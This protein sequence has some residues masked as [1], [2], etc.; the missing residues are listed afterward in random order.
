MAQKFYS[1]YTAEEIEHILNTSDLIPFVI[2]YDAENKVYRF[3]RDEARRD[4]WVECYNNKELALH[5]EIAAYEFTDSFTA[6]AP[7][8]IDITGYTDNKYILYGSTGTTVDY[9][10]VTRDG[11][12]AEVQ[13][14]VDAYYTFKTPVGTT[15]TS[16]IYN[17]GTS[18]SLNVDDYLALGTNVITILL[19]GR[20]TGATKMLVITY[21]VVELD[22]SSTFDISRAIKEN[23]NIEVTYTIKGQGNKIIEFYIDGIKKGQSNVSELE[24]AA[25]RVWEYYNNGDGKLSGG[26]HTLQIQAYTTGDPIFLSKILY[27]EFVVEDDTKDMTYVLIEEVFPNTNN[28]LVGDARPGL[29]G[30]QYIIYTLNW[31]YYTN[32]KDKSTAIITW[33][34]FV[35]GN[36]TTLAT[37]NADV[38]SAETDR[39]PEPLNFMPTE[40]GEYK[41]QAL[42]EGEVIDPQHDYTI[43]VIK[44]TSGLLEATEQL[45]LKLTGLG[46]SNDEPDDTKTSWAWRNQY[47]GV[48][49]NQPWNANSG[50]SE[51]CLILNDGASAEVNASPFNFPGYSIVNN[52]GCTIEIDFETFNVSDDNS[53]LVRMGDLDSQGRGA[54]LLI[55]PSEAILRTYNGVSLSTRYKSDERVKLSFVIYPKNYSPGVEDLNRIYSNCVLIYSNGVMSATMKY[56]S[57]DSFSGPSDSGYLGYIQLGHVISGENEYTGR[58][59]SSIVPEA[60]GAGI[61]IHS[62]RLY[63]TV[64]DMHQI[65]NNFIIDSGDMSTITRLVNRNDVYT[66]ARQISVDKLESLIT[67]VKVTGSLNE[68]IGKSA[69]KETRL[70]CGLEVVCPSNPNINMRCDNAEFRKAGQSTLDKA[71][72]SFHVKLDKNNNVCY[73][74]DNK[75]IVKNR[76]AF[77]EGN[78]PEKKFRLQANYMDSSGAHNG[79]FFRLFNEVAPGVV[80]NGSNVLRM[81]AEEFAVEDY[82]R[83]MSAKYGAENDPR[84]EGWRFPYTL[85][86][87]PDSIPCVVVWRPDSGK[88]YQFLGQYVLMEEKKSNFSNGMRSIYDAIDENGYPD[89]FQFRSKGERIWDNSGC[90]QIELKTSVDDM[91]LFLDDSAWDNRD[92]KGKLVREDQFELVYPDEDDLYEEDPS[93]STYMAEWNLFKNTFLHPIATSKTSSGRPKYHSVLEEAMKGNQDAFNQLYGYNIN[94]WHF[95]AYYCLVLR[96]C[97]SDSTARNME[98]TTYDTFINSD[99]SY[100]FGVSGKSWGGWLPKWWDVDMQCGLYQTGECNL[101]PMTTRTSIAPGTSDSFAL[102][103]RGRVDSLYHSSWLWDGLEQCPQFQQD[104][105]DMDRALYKAGWT[106]SRMN[107]ILDNEYVGSWSESLYNNSGYS[108][109]LFYD[110]TINLQGDRTPHRHWFLKTSYDYFDAVN[111]CGEYT[112]KTINVRTEIPYSARSAEHYIKLTAGVDSFFGWGTSISEDQTGI[113]AAKDEE[114][115]LY[116]TRALQLNNP[117]HIF[118]AS[119][120][121]KLDLS[122]IAPF[123]AADLDLARTYDDITGTYLREVNIGIPK[124]KMHNEH[125]FNNYTALNVVKGIENLTKV[126]IFNIQGLFNMINVSLDRMG[127]LKKFYAAGTRL[128]AFNPASGSKLEE[129]ELPTTVNTMQMEGCSLTKDGECSIKW[130]ETLTGELVSVI[131]YYIYEKLDGS[132]EGPEWRTYTDGIPSNI[133]YDLS[134]TEDLPTNAELGSFAKVTTQEYSNMDI[135]E[136]ETPSTIN[137]LSFRGMGKDIGTQRLIESWLRNINSVGIEEFSETKNYVASDLVQYEG[138]VYKFLEPHYGPLNIYGSDVLEVSVPT[139]EANYLLQNSQI[140]YTSMLWDTDS[141]GEGVDIALLEI[142]ARIPQEA[143]VLSGKIVA[144]GRGEK[145]SYYYYDGLGWTELNTVP[146]EVTYEIT[147]TTPMTSSDLPTSGINSGDIYKVVY[148]NGSF[149][150]EE[151]QFLMNAYGEGIFNLKSSLCI[152]CVNGDITI[153]AVG[154]NTVIDSEGNMHILQGTS[155]RLSATGFPLSNTSSS[156]NWK[157]WDDSSHRWKIPVAGTDWIYF[158]SGNSL[159][160]YTGE[161]VTSE[162]SAATETYLIGVERHVGELITGASQIN[163]E[164]LQRDYPTSVELILTDHDGEY[165]M[166]GDQYQITRAGIYVF[167]TEFT[168]LEFNGTMS[169]DM[170]NSQ[171]GGWTRQFSGNEVPDIERI[172]TNY[173]PGKNKTNQYIL[174]VRN[175]PTSEVTIR[176]GYVSTW[177]NNTT[178]RAYAIN[179]SLIN[180]AAILSDPSNHGLFFL[181]N[182]LGFPH[183][184]DAYTALELKSIG[185]GE[186]DPD[187]PNE[188]YR[189]ISY[190]QYI[191]QFYDGFMSNGRINVLDYLQNVRNIIL[192]NVLSDGCNYPINISGANIFS[193]SVNYNTDDIII[194]RGRI[195]KFTQDH[196]AGPWDSSQVISTSI[197]RSTLFKKLDFRSARA[198]I[199]IGEESDIKE[200]HYGYPTEISIVNPKYLQSIK[201]YTTSSENLTSIE[202]SNLRDN[203]TFTEA[204]NIL[205]NNN[206]V[207]SSGVYGDNP[208]SNLEHVVINQT[209]KQTSGKYDIV[210]YSN[211]TSESVTPEVID[212]LATLCS[213]ELDETSNMTGKL[214]SSTGYLYSSSRA[215]ILTKFNTVSISTTNYYLDFVDKNFRKILSA[216]PANGGW[217]D[218][219][220]LT[221]SNALQINENNFDLSG[222]TG[223]ENIVS[224]AGLKQLTNITTFPTRSQASSSPFTGCTNITTIDFPPSIAKLGAYTFNGNTKLV[225]IDFTGCSSLQEIETNAFYGCTGQARIDL[226]P[227][228]SLISA[229]LSSLTNLKELTIVGNSSITTLII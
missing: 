48:F 216:L 154:D 167:E 170:I 166:V 183:A 114:K 223:K 17:A 93:G 22:I 181:F 10:F 132:D 13:E 15:S 179:I 119:K 215:I 141:N 96:N 146:Q 84:G 218:G 59:D 175:L 118:A 125:I 165:S 62:I 32:D 78:V 176:L 225:N 107:A 228:S 109:Y 136:S 41:L 209:L 227:C 11:T 144:R 121:K 160:Y 76:W 169:D 202:L 200:I 142:L 102:S 197:T 131:R 18:V 42:M 23:T 50:W 153:S 28:I 55:K 87:C 65:L 162:S 25:T 47:S 71:V 36:E 74:R 143:R 187:E 164:I 63:K 172:N 7:Y 155:A 53:V 61:K 226:S 103:G 126:E 156:Y 134:S 148:R 168:P 145:I 135:V 100:T 196:T 86:M 213:L 26:K 185:S 44:N 205:F 124:S 174:N 182:T 77:R 58:V 110:D 80:I 12:L 214:V 57:Q 220:G 6:P 137:V 51:D 52:N 72:P 104:V 138:K 92:S 27:Y 75:V 35:N 221:S 158:G 111:V 56:D 82:P 178:V 91:T 147:T 40:E 67:T 66:G 203:K 9:E 20:S 83:I 31:A 190:N 8:T 60:C 184:S 99:G 37:R 24:T 206:N 19:R 191:N 128:V 152:D 171:E 108:K 39:K 173:A 222:K 70:Y 69:S 45:Q 120:I 123:M 133:T 30:E 186:P 21:Y 188:N 46:R 2:Y 16:N 97:C 210:E 68:I 193:D 115:T 113:P 139:S 94:R 88:P 194:Y 229:D 157:V 33:R 177:K 95:A 189:T 192:P 180:N 79:S 151:M 29:R 38:V 224:L 4:A 1:Q 81:P 199:V 140:S 105:K 49:F 34:L 161:L 106:Y 195:Y 14:S 208:P 85:H 89:P 43:V 54:Q 90:H 98:M 211:C 73:D 150:A 219:Y 5:P 112:S 198:D 201:L 149:T 101:L 116:I 3:F 217:G 204:V 207:G 64:L 129:V 163:V 127:A 117:L 122:D 130:Y 159:N 212:R